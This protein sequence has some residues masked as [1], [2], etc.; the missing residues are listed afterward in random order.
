M[1]VIL[2]WIGG[3]TVAAALVLA[4]VAIGGTATAEGD[5]ARETP[6]AETSAAPEPAGATRFDAHGA[7]AAKAVADA[8]RL[9]TV[10]RILPIDGPIKY[11][12]WHWDDEGVPDGPL[13][14]TVDLQARTISIF[15]GGYEIGAAA[16]LLGTDEHPTPT[17]VFPILWKQ[18]H[19]VS[20]KYGNAPMPWSMFLTSDG[21]AIHGG[22]EVENGY[23]SHG[24]IGVP[25]PIAERL[26]AIATTGDKVVI[27]DG[28]RIGMG[29]SI[30]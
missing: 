10:R 17:G 26:F 5:S 12:E 11:G 22:S 9:Y 6:L 8:E 3:G 16:V 30:I 15:R 20:E 28:Q 24:C 27:T 7:I 1:D 21:V 4:G 25:D 14:V 19:N 13:L 18:R 23:A 29:D 2:K